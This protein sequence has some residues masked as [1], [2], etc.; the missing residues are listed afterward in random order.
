VTQS[1]QAL[2]LNAVPLLVAA[3][4]YLGAAAVH[5]RAPGTHRKLVVPLALLAAG[6]GAFGVVLAVE[7][8]PLSGGI[9]PTFAAALAL[10][11]AGLLLA[12][13]GR[14]ARRRQIAPTATAGEQSAPPLA[15]EL[16]QASD[17]EAIARVF[18]AHVERLVGVDVSALALVDETGR[19]ARGCLLRK[20]GR[21]LE[22]FAEVEFDLEH[23][24]SGVA[25]AVFEG[26]PFAVYDAAASSKV[27]RKIVDAVGAKSTAY[28]PLV[29]HGRVIAVLDALKDAGVSRLAFGAVPR[30]A[31]P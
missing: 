27:S 15:G 26:A 20:D 13:S 24:P 16:A 1:A 28:V 2:W 7:R 4:A 5:A 31:R 18:L 19:R 30:A 14:R 17:A 11:A 22:W 3:A 29:A 8:R 23:Q 6:T 10:L 9:W 21:E 25:T 12:A